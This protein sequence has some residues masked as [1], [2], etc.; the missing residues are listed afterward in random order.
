[1]ILKNSTKK[2]KN[3]AI[4]AAIIIGILIISSTMFF[5]YSNDQTKIKGQMFGNELKQIQDNVKKNTHLY[6]SKISLFKEGNF[7]REK[8]LEYAEKH[9]DEMNKII[10]L[11]DSLQ[12]PNGF[13]TAV[14]LFKLSSETQLESDIQMM[15]WVKTGND[16]AHIRSDVLLQ[17][18]FDYEMAA[19]SEYKLAQG[20]INP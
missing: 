3:S 8:F 18:S 17:E 7:D 13:Q 6:D 20:P 2:K 12:I 10:L 16:A 11:Y 5:V 19:L 1:L 4:Y 15:E 9:R 14:E